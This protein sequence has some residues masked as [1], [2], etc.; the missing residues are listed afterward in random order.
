MRSMRRHSRQQNEMRL[1]MARADTTVL[2]G[3]E[4]APTDAVLADD[5]EHVVLSVLGKLT[6]RVRRD[7]L[8]AFLAPPEQ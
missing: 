1:L 8:A 3:A 5:G 2:W 6:V 4:Q 7:E